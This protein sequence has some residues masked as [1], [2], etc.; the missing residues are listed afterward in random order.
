MVKFLLTLA[1]S[2][3][4]LVLVLIYAAIIGASFYLSYEVRFDFSVASSSQAER[5]RL[6][7]W[8]IGI[9]LVALVLVRQFVSAPGSWT[10]DN[11]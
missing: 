2:R 10:Q 6:V 4:T 7:G 1:H 3:R 8:V 9:K 11:V 5:L